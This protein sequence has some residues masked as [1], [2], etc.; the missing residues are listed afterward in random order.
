M[1][2]YKWQPVWPVW[3]IYLL[4]IVAHL[5]TRHLNMYACKPVEEKPNTSYSYKWHTLL[6]LPEPL[7]IYSIRNE[8]T[9]SLFSSAHFGIVAADCN[10]WTRHQWSTKLWGHGSGCSCIAVSV[11]FVSNY[12]IVY[13]YCICSV[14]NY[15]WNVRTAIWKTT[16]GDVVV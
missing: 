10:R 9:T 12:T 4:K 3:V 8:L 14:F 2:F 15:Q 16:C 7:H 5:I 11:L 13:K 1:A 6:T